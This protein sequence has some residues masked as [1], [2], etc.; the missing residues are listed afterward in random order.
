MCG[1]KGAWPW[2]L[3]LC[4]LLLL[5]EFTYITCN[6]VMFMLNGHNRRKTFFIIEAI[7]RRRRT[8]VEVTSTCTLHYVFIMIHRCCM[9]APSSSFS[10]SH[11]IHFWAKLFFFFLCSTSYN[12]VKYFLLTIWTLFILFRQHGNSKLLKINLFMVLYANYVPPLVK[13][14]P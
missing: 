13:H 3:L 4:V 5:F 9:H 8:L 6:N 1:I 14:I 10:S 2:K 11:I 12:N 7:W